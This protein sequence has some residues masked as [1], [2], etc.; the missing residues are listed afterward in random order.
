LALRPLFA[1]FICKSQDIILFDG[2]QAFFVKKRNFLMGPPLIDCIYKPCLAGYQQSVGK[3]RITK[4]PVSV[5]SV[6][7]GAGLFSQWIRWMNCQEKGA[8]RRY[9]WAMEMDFGLQN[10]EK[11]GMI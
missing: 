3:N 9:V 8:K 6:P 10:R 7:A 5:W 2:L 11:L 4:S 1:Y